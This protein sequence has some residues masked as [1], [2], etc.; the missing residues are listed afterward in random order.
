MS[1]A[2][3]A[4]QKISMPLKSGFLHGTGS[5]KTCWEQHSG[6][7][8]LYFSLDPGSMGYHL[9][10]H[11]QVPA[12]LGFE[13]QAPHTELLN[14]HCCPGSGMQLPPKKSRPSLLNLSSVTEPSFHSSSEEDQV[15]PS[16][17]RL[18]VNGGS[19]YE[20][21]PPHT[22]L[23]SGER[24]AKPLPPL[25]GPGTGGELSPD[26]VDSEVEFFTSSDSISLVQDKPAAFRRSFRGCGQ[27]NLA[28]FEGPSGPRIEED[29][30]APASSCLP[31]HVEEKLAVAEE[32]ACRRQ[33][34]RPH[35]RLR[36]SHSG[37]AGSFNKPVLKLSCHR[38]SQQDSEDKPVVPPR[39]PIPPRPVKADYR[40]WSAEV[41]SSSAYS[42]EDK[43]PKVPPREPVPRSGSRTPSPK[44]LPTYTN[45][46]MPTTQSFAPNPKYVSAKALHRQNSEGSPTRSPCI[47]PIMENGRKASTTHYYLLPERPAYLDRFEKFFSE[48]ASTSSSCTASTTT[49]PLPEFSG[50]ADNS[51]SKWQPWSSGG[52]LLTIPQGSN[53]LADSRA[54]P[55]T[56]NH[57]QQKQLLDIVSL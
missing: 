54:K 22:P 48:A 14:S 35:R 12:S 33:H 25:P 24:G 37:P 10:Q 31:Q 46:V 23:R 42:D 29:R 6:L 11:Q 32:S 34:E 13:R 9:K 51:D 5:A 49:A 50:V 18:S 7:E 57:V 20:R 21:T 2:G 26:E 39:V 17:K 8:N 36:R 45:G 47:L 43:P 19:F 55:D 40:R 30:S 1:T 53:R 52:C 56:V 38:A 27:V 44:S 15:V 16:F 41:A 28:Y 4:A 3:L